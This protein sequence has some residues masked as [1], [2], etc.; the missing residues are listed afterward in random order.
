M[1]AY[2]PTAVLISGLALLVTT[3]LPAADAAAEREPPS[4]VA[5]RFARAFETRDFTTVR[6]LLAPEAVVQRAALSRTG[7]PRHSRFTARGWA[8]EAERN[9]AFLKDMKLEILDTQTLG[10]DHGA[11]VNLRY[12]FTGRAGQRAFVTN[13]IDTYA[14]VPVEGSWRILQYSY[15]ELLEF[16]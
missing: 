10:F 9:H 15:I 11:I 6:S 13:G 14:M 7:P 12:R 4:A 5:T 3:L 2:R 16:P 1:R 8:D